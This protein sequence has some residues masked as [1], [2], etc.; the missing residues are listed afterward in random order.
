MRTEQRRTPIVI[1][2][3]DDDED[4]I[5]LVRR[6]LREADVAGDFHSV[7]DGT[8][9]LSYLHGRDGFTPQ[10][11]PRPQLILLDLNMPRLGG[12]KTLQAIKQHPE[13]TTIPVVVFS[14]SDLDEDVADSYS[15]GAASYIHKPGSFGELVQVMKDIGRYWFEVVDLAQPRPTTTESLMG[16]T[17]VDGG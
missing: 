15:V 9:L 13:L 1:V 5:F 3:A 7:G 17:A 6:A 16:A 11:A 12:I 14:T 2:M 4:D 10:T 8:E